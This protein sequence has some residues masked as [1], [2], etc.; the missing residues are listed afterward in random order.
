MPQLIRVSVDTFPTTVE[1]RGGDRHPAREVASA[2]S[3]ILG[4]IA[5]PTVI[6]LPSHMA[7]NLQPAIQK[8]DEFERAD[9]AFFVH[10]LLG[11]EAKQPERAAQ[12]MAYEGWKL[13]GFPLEQLSILPPGVCLIYGETKEGRLENGRHWAVTCGDNRVIQVTGVGFPIRIT[14]AEVPLDL[15]EASAVVAAMPTGSG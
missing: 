13:L 3:R 2:K 12:P 11:R 8:I 7:H 14:A 15:Y 9:C 5:T 6:T 1:R 4:A 10:T